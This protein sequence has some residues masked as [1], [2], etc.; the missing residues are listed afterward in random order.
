MSS[1]GERPPRTTK[2]ETDN[3][4]DH[5]HRAA[6][7]TPHTPTVIRPEGAWPAPLPPVTEAGGPSATDEGGSRG[8]VPG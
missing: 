5:T 7:M 8:E 4:T 2:D 3:M 1:P 6:Q